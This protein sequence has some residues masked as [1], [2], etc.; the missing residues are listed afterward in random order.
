[1]SSLPDGYGRVTCLCDALDQD[2]AGFV[3][4]ETLTLCHC[5]A[6]RHSSGVLFT[7]YFPIDRPDL[8]DKLRCWRSGTAARYFCFICGCHLF[9]ENQ[10]SD[11]S[12]KWGVATGT[13]TT[14]AGPVS[15]IAPMAQH[16]LV[17][18]TK[19]GGASIWIEG[20]MGS[21]SAG[22]HRDSRA[23]SLPWVANAPADSL[24][25][26]CA[27]GN[28]RFHITRPNAQSYEPHSNYPDLMLADKTTPESVK[29]NPNRDKWWI[30]EGGEKYLAGTCA[31]RSCRLFTGFEIQQWAFVPKTNIFFHTKEGS[32]VD[33][34]F[35]KLPEG[36]LKTFSSS[37]GVFR[38]FCGGCGATV[39]WHDTSRPGII[40]VSVG[41]LLAQE[42]SRA[43][44]WLS[45]WTE[46][47]SFEEDTECGRHGFPRNMA[48]SLVTAL[49]RGLRTSE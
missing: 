10:V 16:V 17:D 47:V 5:Y 29:C 42:G 41:I 32:V 25:A 7:S 13:V 3:P 31:C 12:T 39:F 24:P 33:L 11:E 48:R 23:A 8:S 34:D 18:D 35:D 28:V 14:A 9:I 37:P 27:C 49:E 21:G 44:D 38:E 4:E 19:D 6:C 45:W 1:M 26:A 22:Y 40:D 15:Q 36:T 46:R 43:D 30:Q 20:L 2:I